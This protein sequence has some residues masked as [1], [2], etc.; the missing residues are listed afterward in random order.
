MDTKAG[1]TSPNL[2][3][4]ILIMKMIFQFSLHDYLHLHD[5]IHSAKIDSCSSDGLFC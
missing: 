4:K 5:Y 1:S 3:G 2:R